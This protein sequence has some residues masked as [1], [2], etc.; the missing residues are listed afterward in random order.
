MAASF[1]GITGNW[2]IPED[3]SGIIIT[4]LSF[5]YSSQEK[6]VLDKS[7]EVQGIVN[8]QQKIEIKLSGLVKKT[9][10]FAG[11]IGTALVLA[12]N[13]PSHL[14]GDSAGL[15]VIKQIQRSLNN[16]DFEKIEITATYYPFVTAA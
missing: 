16:E 14:Q 5:D 13:I 15:T 9:G 1:L 4:D 7:G 12:N 6:L 8:Y 3:E 10:P 11:R 2:G